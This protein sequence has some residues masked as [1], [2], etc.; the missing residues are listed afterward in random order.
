M[1]DDLQ[2]AI[3]GGDNNQPAPLGLA[4]PPPPV[5]LSQFA[6]QYPASV[7]A[8][9]Q[10]IFAQ[11]P[12]Q[13]SAFQ[14]QYGGNLSNWLQSFTQWWT[15]YGGQVSGQMQN[16]QPEAS[17]LGALGYSQNPGN[18]NW[19]ASGNAV[20]QAPPLPPGATATTGP[21]V[22]TTSEPAEEGL[23]DETIGGLNQEVLND[24]NLANETQKLQGENATNYGLLGDTLG[25]AIA[26][27]GQNSGVTNQENAAAQASAA[28]Q[29]TALQQSIKAMQGSLTGSLAAQAAAL[30]QSLNQIQSNISTYGDTASQALTTQINQQLQDLQGSIQSQKASLQTQIQTLSGAADTASQQQLAAL[31]TQLGQL[32]TAEAPV[33]QARTAAAQAQVTAVNIGEAQAKNQIAGQAALQGFVGGSSMEDNALAQ[34]GIGAQQAGAADVGE[35]SLQNAQDFQAISDL[36]ANSQDS[37]ANQLAQQK[38][39]I[40]GQGATGEY[41]LESELATGTQGLQD[42][43]AQGQAAI[44]NTV[45]GQ[46]ESAGN[47]YAEQNYGNVN[48]GIAAQ[49]SL[50]DALAQGQQGITSTEAQQQQANEQNQYSQSLQA[51]L[52]NAALPGQEASSIAATDNLQNAGLLNAQQALNWW[53]APSQTPTPATS[54]STASNAGNTLAAAG[55][56]LLNAATSIG[57]SNNWWQTPAKTTTPAPSTSTATNPFNIDTGAYPGDPNAGSAAPGP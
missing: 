17:L 44:K 55:S 18:G 48:T 47:T 13:A 22:P 40:T 26:P 9:A 24:Q 5:D 6:S 20:V 30:L 49:N 27:P 38:Q 56:G 3:T 54:V 11:Q 21:N 12:D 32:N 25:N 46:Q 35:A 53:A 23:Y 8:A 57:N 52:A 1:A 33:A 37:L 28:T 2:T 15:N 29:L 43:G 14:S 19:I 4:T 51:A 36:G 34:A 31:Q 50:A 41:N 39:A 16:F 10:Q 45:A 42:Q 7:L